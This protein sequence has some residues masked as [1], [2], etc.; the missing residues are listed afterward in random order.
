MTSFFMCPKVN[1][2]KVVDILQVND[3]VFTQEVYSKHLYRNLNP[4][5]HRL[6]SGY[7]KLLVH[8]EKS[9][10]FNLGNCHT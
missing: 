4:L 10:L 1:L 8:I 6:L 5:L 7:N 2:V 3:I 9:D